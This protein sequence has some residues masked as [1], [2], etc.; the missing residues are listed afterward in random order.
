[1]TGTDVI[2]A[3]ETAGLKEG[4]FFGLA[5]KEGYVLG[6]VARKEPV[7]M[8]YD[9]VYTVGGAPALVPGNFFVPFNQLQDATG[10]IL[11][12]ANRG[13][14]IGGLANHLYH[15]FVGISPSDARMWLRYPLSVPRWNLDSKPITPGPGGDNTYGFL[16]GNISP[17]NN[18]SLQSE[19]V[20]PNWADWEVAFLNDSQAARFL[21]IKVV[22][23]RYYVRILK[24]SSNGKVNDQ[25]CIDKIKA[26]RVPVRLM[27]MGGVEPMTFDGFPS[28]NVNPIDI[29]ADDSD[30]QS[31][32][33]GE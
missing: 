17:Y 20:I 25:R 15:L 22:G 13:R 9:R 32:Q 31:T 10:R 16:D 2:N 4:W 24:P 19:L 14:G 8:E 11:F 12:G 33:G 21:K 18:P 26:N 3:Y 7:S 1:M 28:W 6:R 23:W 30:A 5:F 29:F 27:T